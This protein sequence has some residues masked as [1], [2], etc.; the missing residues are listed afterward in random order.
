MSVTS[1]NPYTSITWSKV[2]CSFFIFDQMLYGALTRLMMRT[3]MPSIARRSAS[4]CSIFTIASR[5]LP[6]VRLM[7][8][9]MIL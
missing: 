3:G 4:A 6:S 7:R 1:R 9:A 5:R 8:E 2:L